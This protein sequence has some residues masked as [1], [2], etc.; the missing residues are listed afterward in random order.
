PAYWALTAA[1][2]LDNCDGSAELAALAPPVVA[3]K[4]TAKTPTA[5]VIRVKAVHGRHTFCITTSPL[6]LVW[7]CLHPGASRHTEL[8]TSSGKRKARRI[9]L[10]RA[11]RTI[12]RSWPWSRF[13]LC[14]LA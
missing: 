2:D 7:P 9:L 6:R 1:G 14:P 3:T 4:T 13:P 8:A 5:A 10:A 11:F 12:V